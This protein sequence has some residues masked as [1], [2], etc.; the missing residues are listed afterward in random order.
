MDAHGEYGDGLERLTPVYRTPAPAPP[1]D[2]DLELKK[3][4]SPTTVSVGELVTWT[5]TVTNRST[6]VAADVSGARVVDRPFRMELVSLTTSP[7]TCSPPDRCNL[8]RLL[9]GGSVTVTAVTKATQAGE[10][11]NCVGVSWRKSS[12]ATST[13]PPV[14]LPT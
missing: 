11:V 8:G 13:T 12:P 3:T 4:A 10:V 5:M 1:D 7:G 14:Q 9:P 6:V 2:L